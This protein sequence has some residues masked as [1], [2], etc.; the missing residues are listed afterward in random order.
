MRRKC[1]SAFEE[2]SEIE[3]K[4]EESVFFKENGSEEINEERSVPLKKTVN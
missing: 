2:N 4:E 1:H 3:I